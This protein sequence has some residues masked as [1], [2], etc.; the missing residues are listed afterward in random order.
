[1]T[2]AL[3]Q[4]SDMYHSL[5]SENLKLA[6]NTTPGDFIKKEEFDEVNKNLKKVT[7]KY[8]NLKKVLKV[9]KEE[10]IIQKNEFEKNRILGEIK[11]KK[12]FLKD[13]EEADNTIMR[14]LE[15][16]HEEAKVEDNIYIEDK[17]NKK[18]EKNENKYE[19][20]FRISENIEKNENFEIK[21]K[22]KKKNISS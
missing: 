9:N 20:N 17:N 21:K 11:I 3:K 22:K 19:N 14:L 4:W 7:K 1:M 12:E 16:V 8:K 5:K 15:D 6:E 10:Y 18:C 13:N 2:K